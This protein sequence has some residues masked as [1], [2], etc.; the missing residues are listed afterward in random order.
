MKKDIKEY[1]LIAVTDVLDMPSVD[2]ARGYRDN[3]GTLGPTSGIVKHKLD[4]VLTYGWGRD[5][6][7]LNPIHIREYDGIQSAYG[8]RLTDEYVGRKVMGNG[9]HRFVYETYIQG[10]L[11]VHYTSERS[12]SGW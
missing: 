8:H 3:K 11:F 12:E 7:I 6:V 5:T 2:N 1:P 10:A 4:D 9:H